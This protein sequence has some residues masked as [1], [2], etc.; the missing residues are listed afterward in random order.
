[1]VNLVLGVARSAGLEDIVVVIPEHDEAIPNAVGD[2]VSH[3]VQPTPRGKPLGTGDAVSRAKSS[4]SG[5]DTVVVMNADVPLIRSE[6]INS[7]IREHSNKNAAVSIVTSS[8]G[9]TDGLGRVKRSESREIIAIVEER[10]ADD[11]ELAIREINVGAYCFDAPWL[12]EN[13][14]NIPLASNGEIYLTGLIRLAADQCKI[15]CSV[16]TTKPYESLGINTRIQLAQAESFL[17]GSIRDQWMLN[18]VTIADPESV[19]ID[20]DVQIGIDT[21]IY[22]NT[23]IRGRSKIGEDCEIGPNSVILDSLIGNDCKVISSV[24]EGSTME[25]RSDVGPYSHI[26]PG[27]KLQ[28]NVHVGNFAEVKESRLGPGTKIGHFSYIGDAEV[29]SNV[30]IGAGTIT[31]NYDGDTKNQTHIGD[32]VFVGS[33]TMLIAPVQL[34]D[35]SATGAGS[36]VNKDVPPDAL[37]IGA[38]ARIRSKKRP[39]NTAK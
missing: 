37:A 38:P 30:N 24:V 21:V 5:F 19:Y 23:H 3:T 17:R 12:W 9:N 4:A 13:I 11:T 26:R 36:I 14:D 10:D 18:G 34:G 29:G 32:D 20:A 28:K 39:K 27:S 22:P 16:P 31:C 35:R 1:M 8:L 7:L 6:T 15:I 25:D 33:D 2:E